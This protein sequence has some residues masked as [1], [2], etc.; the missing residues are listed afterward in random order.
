MTAR[1]RTTVDRTAF[2]R[3]ADRDP[4]SVLALSCTRLPAGTREATRALAL[5]PAA[6]TTSPRACA[7]TGLTPAAV[8]H[9]FDTLPPSPHRPTTPPADSPWWPEPSHRPPPSTPAAL[10][11]L[12]IVTPQGTSATPLRGGATWLI[13]VGALR[14]LPTRW[15]G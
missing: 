3:T 13:A 6:T 8:E 4:T 11:A 9:L 12:D 7:T 5:H 2:L 15:K 10:S 14:T 1:L